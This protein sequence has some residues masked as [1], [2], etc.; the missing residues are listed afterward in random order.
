MF[1]NQYRRGKGRFKILY[2]EETT[3]HL[4]PSERVFLAREENQTIT[5]IL[6]QYRWYRCYN[7]SN[8]F[9]SEESEKCPHKR[10]PLTYVTSKLRNR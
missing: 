1:D 9:L 3:I 6:H 8:G 5:V 10:N 2:L 7:L 4:P